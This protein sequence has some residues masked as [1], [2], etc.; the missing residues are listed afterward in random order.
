MRWPGFH[1]ARWEAGDGH[2]LPHRVPMAVCGD[3]DA[4]DGER[5][6]RKEHSRTGLG[7]SWRGSGK[8]APSGWEGN[9]SQPG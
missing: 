1:W 7:A 4:R 3:C 8:R 5:I 6:H 9:S 2:Q